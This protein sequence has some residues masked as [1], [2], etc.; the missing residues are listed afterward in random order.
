MQSL[1]L[2]SM[3]DEPRFAR[4]YR[5]L[6]AGGLVLA[7]LFAVMS[8]AGLFGATTYAREAPAWG[9]QAIAQD[10]FDLVLGCPALVLAA[11]W[12]GRGSRRGLLVYA[13][14]L[15]FAVYTAAIYAFAV[16]LNAAFLVYCAALGIGVYSL[17]GALGRLWQARQGIG[18]AADVPRR[19]AGGFLVAVGAV[20]ALLWLGQL[21]PAAIRGTIPDELA[22]TGLLTNPVHVLDLSFIL[23]LHV[24]AGV[25]LWRRRSPIWLLGPVLLVFGTLMAA[26][27]A[28][29]A[30]VAGSA[31][32]T[33]AMGGLAA[34][35]ARFSA[36]LI[37]GIR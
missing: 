5:L 4:R 20:F 12:A 16:H 2:A 7:I 32:V 29:L 18:L 1:H 35:S 10:L 14:T 6:A 8:V 17:I 28:V 33:V 25:A 21:V 24:I 19:S 11:A 15:L 9:E 31:S 13:G 30:F 34:V 26:S 23:P 27:I 36:C 22:A 37:R 3:V